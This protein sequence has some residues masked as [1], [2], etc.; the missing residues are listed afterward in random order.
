MWRY[1]FF[2]TTYW[3]SPNS[4]SQK[5][6]FSQKPSSTKSSSFRTLL[7]SLQCLADH[8]SKSICF[9]SDLDLFFKLYWS[10]YLSK[11]FCL[12]QITGRQS[13]SIRD[14]SLLSISA[15]PYMISEISIGKIYHQYVKFMRRDKFM[16]NCVSVSWFK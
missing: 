8:R 2:E 1:Y 7:T 11:I 4:G 5:F 14:G 10:R 15:Y 16:C 9:N 3:Y 12:E 6:L 13:S